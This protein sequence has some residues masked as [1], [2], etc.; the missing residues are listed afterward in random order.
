MRVALYGA[1]GKVGVLLEPALRRGRARRRR[2]ARRSGRTD[3][4]RRSTSRAPTPSSRTSRRA[5]RPACP[6]VIGTTG[7]DLDAL[8]AA[9]REAGVPCFHAPN[10]AQGA[11][12]MMRFAEE[13]AK[14]FPRA[15]IVELHSEAKR[16]APSGTAKAT[17]ARMGTDPGHPLR[18][19]PGPRRAPGG[20]LRRRGGDAHDPA[21]HDLA[22]G[23]RARCAARARA[24]DASFRRASRSGLRRAPLAFNAVERRQQLL[25]PPL[26]VR[27]FGVERF[28]RA[29]ERVHRLHYEEEDRG[30]RRDERDRAVRKA[31]YGTRRR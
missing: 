11:V 8:D 10:F 24:G 3:A 28:I 16:D 17:A 27:A 21:R 15:E 31:P 13:A 4:T 25:M 9:A 23:L 22:R 2:R 20:H 18:P 30:R 5:S 29:R 7:F 6:V 26:L 1:S 14:V 19:P 12:L